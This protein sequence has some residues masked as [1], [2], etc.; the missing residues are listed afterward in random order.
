M[1]EKKI[2]E[3]ESL[4]LISRMIY[5]AKGY[6]YE[7]GMAALVYGF[8]ILLCS[9]LTFMMEKKFISFPFHPFYILIPIFLIQTRIQYKLEKKK[10]AKTFTDEAID[11]VWI[12]FFLASIASFSAVFAGL[13]YVSII[14]IF[15]LMAFACFLTGMLS[16]FRYHVVC[17]IVCLIVGAVSF[18]IQNENIYL[19]LAAIAILVWVIPGFILRSKF[20]ELHK[21]ETD[22]RFKNV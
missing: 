19:L 22:L 7:N 21:P 4:Q 14:I 17:S 11:Y 12:G 6:Y 9:A 1:E 5:E 15:F 20:K 3:Q 2:S 8:S 10:K 16:K 18:F 13:G